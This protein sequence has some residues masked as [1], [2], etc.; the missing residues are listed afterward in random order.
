MFDLKT[1]AG[2]A[3]GILIAFFSNDAAFSEPLLRSSSLLQD[4]VPSASVLAL[5]SAETEVKILSIE[6]GWVLVEYRGQKGWLRASSLKLE[7]PV[8]SL[9]GLQTGRQAS[10]PFINAA[11]SLGVRG[12]PPRSNRHAL[13][14][15][16]SEYAVSTV[17]PLPGTRHDRESATQIALAMQIPQQN[18]VYLRDSEASGAGIRKAIADLNRKVQKGDR[19]FI[20]FTG[21]GTRYF[22]PDINGCVEALLP[23]DATFEGMIS[24]RDLA[25]SLKPI[26]DKVDKMMVM[27]DACH[28]GGV[29]DQ[30]PSIASTRG[31]ITP[32][33]DGRLSPKFSPSSASC[34]APSNVK[35]R[36]L[37]VEQSQLGVFSQDVILI[38]ASRDHQVSFEDAEKG[39]LATQ[40]MRD[41]ML[42]EAKDLNGSGAISIDEIAQCAQSKI[43]KRLAGVFGLSPHQ[44][45]IKGNKEFVPAWFSQATLV[46]SQPVFSSGAPSSKQTDGEKSLN[47]LFEQRDAKHRLQVIAAKTKLKIGTDKVD[48]TI[49]SSEGGYVYVLLAGSDNKSTYLL[50]PNELDSNNRIESSHPL[51]LPRDSWQMS[52]GGPEGVNTIL[53]IVASAP[54]DVSAL[55]LATKVGPF[56]KTVNDLAGRV[57]LGALMTNANVSGQCDVSANEKPSCSDAFGAEILVIEEVR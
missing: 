34:A 25:V 14:I 20:Y 12:L 49:T 8:S 22:D 56:M 47:Q 39:G 13:I 18:I 16:I 26:T 6:G 52:A 54:R 21:H 38:S 28:S 35:S 24:N 4:K 33:D 45:Q 15:S 48:L 1:I 51:R 27:Y 2:F 50:F 44:I 46:A 29:I 36:S 42:R 43:D 53:I 55:P 10:G 31:F 5:I 17:S 30:S 32:Q 11:I 57:A 3:F 23:Y 37:S 19:V 7:L 41:C 9:S 40:F